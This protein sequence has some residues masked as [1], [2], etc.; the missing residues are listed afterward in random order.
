MLGIP[1][2]AYRVLTSG[3]L[4]DCVASCCFMA[5]KTC[6]WNAYLEQHVRIS[7]VWVVLGSR[8]STSVQKK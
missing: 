8:V 7:H 5:V 6:L 4:H 1:V 3:D 2:K